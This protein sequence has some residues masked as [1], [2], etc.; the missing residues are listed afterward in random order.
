MKALSEFLR[1]EFLS[2]ID[3]IVVF[4]PLTKENFCDIAALMLDEMKEPLEEKGI[5]FSY[6]KAALE[7]IADKA[8]GGKFG[9][10]DIRRVIRTD[11]EDKTAQLIIDSDKGIGAIEVSA[12]N[13]EITVSAK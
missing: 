13:G 12:E 5:A 11:V 3:E 8:F 10:R 9:A 1:P 6:D 7:A 4:D 2:R